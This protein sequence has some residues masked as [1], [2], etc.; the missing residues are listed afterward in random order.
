MA[1]L[2]HGAAS[3]RHPFAL[4]FQY[5]FFFYLIDLIE[6]LYK[7]LNQM[8]SQRVFQTQSIATKLA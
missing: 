4:H 3:V 8:D 7:C 2:K 1:Y 5:Q 6:T